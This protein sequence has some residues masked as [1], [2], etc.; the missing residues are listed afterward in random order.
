MPQS[1]NLEGIPLELLDVGELALIH[2]N[3]R[4]MDTWLLDQLFPNRP[5]FD[6]DDVPLAE[7]SSE[8]DLAP[9]VSPHQPGK[10]FDT[11]QSSS[12]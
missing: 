12:S 3:Y 10:P 5:V 2:N 11:T 6:R 8:H 1:F 9:L 4:P 7:V